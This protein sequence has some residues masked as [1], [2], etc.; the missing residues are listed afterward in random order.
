MSSP[1]MRAKFRVNSVTPPE[2][3]VSEGITI[4][5]PQTI[6]AF[7]VGRSDSSPEDGSDEDN[8]YAKFSPSGSLELTIVNPQL[9]NKIKEGDVFYVEFTKAEAPAAAAAVDESTAKT[10][11]ANDS[12][13]EAAAAAEPGTA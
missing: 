5:P 6:K 11:A 3:P 1:L 8:S 9:S 10:V 12:T 13:G 4:A 2:V 7:P